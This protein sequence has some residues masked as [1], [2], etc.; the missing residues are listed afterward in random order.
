MKPQAASH[1]IN[2]AGA[3]DADLA[4]AP[5]LIRASRENSHVGEEALLSVNTDLLRQ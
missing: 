1:R 5:N 3:V 2:A 4:V